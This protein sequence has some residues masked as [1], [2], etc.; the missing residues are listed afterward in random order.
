M[1]HTHGDEFAALDRSL[2]SRSWTFLFEVAGSANLGSHS[3]VGDDGD[4]INGTARSRTTLCAP[5]Y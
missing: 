4:R 1:D 5:G 2:G 3:T